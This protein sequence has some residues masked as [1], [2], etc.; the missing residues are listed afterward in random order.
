M[1]RVLPLRRPGAGQIAHPIR[2]G[3]PG[4]A[5]ASGSIAEHLGVNAVAAGPLDGAACASPRLDRNA[6]FPEKSDRRGAEFARKVC[7]A[8]PV[9]KDECL[10]RYGHLQHGV[11]AG[12]T[13]AERRAKRAGGGR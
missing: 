8:C 5:P 7:A 9:N 11:V 2:A 6:M 10:A 12:L 1:N 4:S 13:V 3:L